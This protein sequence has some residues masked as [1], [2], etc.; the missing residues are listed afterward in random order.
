[1]PT[2]SGPVRAHCRLLLCK[3]QTLSF[4]ERPGLSAADLRKWIG[5][6]TKDAKD[7]ER[8]DNPTTQRKSHEKQLCAA[9]TVRELSNHINGLSLPMAAMHALKQYRMRNCMEWTDEEK[10]QNWSVRGGD[11]KSDA[12]RELSPLPG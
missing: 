5:D 6:V 11:N 1:M 4:K 7:I 9:N 8:S 10:A 12:Q 3:L 2:V